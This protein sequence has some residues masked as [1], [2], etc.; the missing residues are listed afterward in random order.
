[1]ILS[2]DV[3]IRNLALCL[4][5]EDRKN[6]VTEWDVDG[7]PPQHADGIYVS[8]RNHLDERPWVLTAKTILIEE[9]PSFNKKMVSVMHFL[10]AYFIIKCP[11]AET[12][13]YHASNKIPDISGPGKAQYN[14]RRMIWRIQ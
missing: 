2:I 4:L 14:K 11:K 3:G 8:L 1:M 10:H 12:I 9:Q 7:I 5:D 6:L 13:I